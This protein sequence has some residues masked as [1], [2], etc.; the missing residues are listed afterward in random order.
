M[1]TPPVEP[2]ALAACLAIVAAAGVVRGFAG[3]GFSALCVAGLS[4]LTS[5]AQVVPA[6]FILEVLA[7]LT[8]LRSAARDID[9]PW[10]GWLVLGNALCI[11]VGIALLAFLPEQ[12][13]RLVIGL[14]LLAAALLLRSGVGLSLAPT[15]AARLGTGLVSG[16]V[17]GLAA[18]GGMAVA[19]LLSTTQMAPATL[20]ATL[21]ALFLFTDLWALAAAATLSAA[22]LAPVDL[23]G[24][25]TL[26]WAAW[27]AP[28]M[29]AG[30]RVGE[31]CFKG[32]S[33][34]RFRHSVLD[35]LTATALLVV[36]R[37]GL[38]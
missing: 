32:V 24:P 18:V 14:L 36:L 22:G 38:G 3:F 27:M 23:L 25:D 15:A 21:I 2:A 6:I 30:I 17:N 11:P 9:V 7:S 12:Q 37:A 8:L 16:L 19:V 35:L 31:R 1:L 33:P 34:A 5:P 20:R 26:R 10:L 28:A 29:L 4:L 13:L